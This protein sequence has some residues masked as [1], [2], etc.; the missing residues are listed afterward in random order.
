MLIGLFAL[1]PGS[2]RAL[3]PPPD[4]ASVAQL[5]MKS[6]DRGMK[7]A[8]VVLLQQCL[9]RDPA[10]Y[11]EGFITGYFGQL[12]E[13]AVQRFQTRYLIVSSGTPATTGYGRVGPLTRTWLNSVCAQTALP[14]TAPVGGPSAPPA[15]SVSPIED[16]TQF[17]AD[18]KQINVNE[19]LDIPGPGGCASVAAC[20][21]FC[22][23][24]ANYNACAQFL[25]AP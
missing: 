18:V 24:S 23:A 11:P 3:T 1:M 15:I 25:L 4:G 17:I 9:A 6:L 21:Q 20:L 7:D 5:F 22:A 8:E 12:T 16:Q 10:L 2:T 13:R 19:P 14:T